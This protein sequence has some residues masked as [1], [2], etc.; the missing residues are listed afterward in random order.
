MAYETG[1]IELSNK[2]SGFT[3][4]YTLDSTNV[5]GFIQRR[6]PSEVLGTGCTTSQLITPPY[7]QPMLFSANK[8]T[9]ISFVQEARTTSSTALYAVISASDSFYFA[10]QAFKF[11]PRTSGY[12]FD[13]IYDYV[14]IALDKF[15]PYDYVLYVKTEK[16]I[17][18]STGTINIEN[19]FKST[20]VFGLLINQNPVYGVNSAQGAIYNGVVLNNDG[21]YS[22]SNFCLETRDGWDYVNNY[23]T[24]NEVLTEETIGF[25]RR[26]D[27][28]IYQPGTYDVLLINFPDYKQT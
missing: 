9:G 7:L 19:P 13:G 26:N 14:F 27:S 5:I 20:R 16:T 6:N 21:N 22:S 12:P 18:T 3:I 23:A 1:I 10:D 2:T 8:R 17:T 25:G 15:R 11:I 28:C 24:T 4:P